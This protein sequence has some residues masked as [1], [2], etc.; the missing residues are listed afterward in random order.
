MTPMS[1]QSCMGNLQPILSHNI[2]R[3]NDP[4]AEPKN[5]TDITRFIDSEYFTGGDPDQAPGSPLKAC[6]EMNFSSCSWYTSSGKPKALCFSSSSPGPP[7]AK[8][9]TEAR[10]GKMTAVPRIS[11]K[12]AKMV[13]A[14]T[15]SWKL[16]LVRSR[17]CAAVIRE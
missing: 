16:L 12:T 5:P 9:H 13:T 15:T 7:S 8:V 3:N 11:A 10:P 17:T 14:T 6:G 4:A 2:P 1:K